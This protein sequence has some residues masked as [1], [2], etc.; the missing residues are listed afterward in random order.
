MPG[1]KYEE[2][3]GIVMWW[4]TTEKE[5]GTVLCQPANLI[6]GKAFLIGGKLI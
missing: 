3:E 4:Q 5:E 6:K 2:R 1:N